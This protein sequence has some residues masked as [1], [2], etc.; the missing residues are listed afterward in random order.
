MLVDSPGLALARRRRRWLGHRWSSRWVFGL[1]L[2][3]GAG[4]GGRLL[5][6]CNSGSSRLRGSFAKR[7]SQIAALFRLGSSTGGGGGLLFGIVLLGCPSSVLVMR[8][9][10]FGRLFVSLGRCLGL[11]GVQSGRPHSGAFSRR[12]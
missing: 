3:R 2:R 10:P 9:I 8:M 1:R 7:G 11:V 12:T 5:G 6:G 4:L